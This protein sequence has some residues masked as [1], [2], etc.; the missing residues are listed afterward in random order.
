[1][2]PASLR[3]FHYLI[4]GYR[5]RC[6]LWQGAIGCDLGKLSAPEVLRHSR[7]G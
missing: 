2:C 3:L 5:D 1:M 6:R 4:N 7:N